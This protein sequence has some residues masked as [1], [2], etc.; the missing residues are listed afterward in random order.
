MNV[1]LQKGRTK[2]VST[3]FKDDATRTR[4][5]KLSSD[6]LVSPSIHSC[7]F[8]F[9]NH[10]IPFSKTPKNP[11]FQTQDLAANEMHG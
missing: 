11:I 7:K 4:N 9:Q 3:V 10:P 2:M 6:G 8:T 1:G 5:L